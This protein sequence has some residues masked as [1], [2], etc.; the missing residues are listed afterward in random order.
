[1]S[2][3]S[4]LEDLCAAARSHGA[5]TLALTDTNGLYGAVRFIEVA[6]QTGLHPILGAELTHKQHR[7][8]LLSTSMTGYTN[9]CRLLSDRHC[10]DNF[11]F[12]EAVAQH[13]HDLLVL[14]DDIPALIVW[15]KRKQK[16][17]YV[18]LTPGVMMHQAVAFSRRSGIPP[19]ATN[20][21]HFVQPE[22]FSLHTVLQAIALKTTLSQL[23]PTTCCSPNHWLAPAAVLEPQYT[24]IPHALLNA[25]RIAERCHTEWN[26]KETVQQAFRD[27]TDPQTFSTL[28]AKTYEGAQE[29]YGE[30]SR[31][32]EKRIETELSVIRSKGFAVWFLIVQDIVQQAPR[33]CGRG[34]AAASI[35]SYCLGITHVDPIRHN[36]FFERFLNAGRQDPPD[37]DI[38]FPWDERDRILDYIFAKYGTRRTA[39][40]ANHNT[41]GFRAAIREVAKVYGISPTELNRVIP[42]LIRQ[43]EFH[44]PPTTRTLTAW[45]ANICQTMGMHEPW[46]AIISV[47][48]RLEGCLRHLGVHCGGVVIAPDEIQRYVPV[49]VSTKGVPI[50]QWEKDQTEDAGLVKLDILGNRSLAVIRDT[51]DAVE[52]QTGQRLNTASWNPICDTRTQELIRQTKTIGCFY[53]ESPATRLLLRKLWS[54]LPN[55]HLSELDIFEYVVMVSSLVRPAGNPY[56][57][58]FVLRAHGHPHQPVHPIFERV[59]ADTHG[60]MVYQEDVTRV[61]MAMADFSVEDADQLR[62]ILSKKH[63]KRQLQD[64]QTQFS[65]GAAANGA[66]QDATATMWNMIMSFAGYSFCKPHSASYA[67]VS[68]Q[69]AYL[70]AHYPAEFMAA[71]VN[72]QGGFY[73]TFV[74]LSEARRMGLTILPPDINTS[75]W[76]YTGIGHTIRMGFIQIKGLKTDVIDD[77]LDERTKHG[78][79]R[80]LQNFLAR[81]KSEQAQTRILVK[82]GAFDRIAGEVTRAGLLWRLYAHHGWQGNKQRA[83][84]KLGLSAPSTSSTLRLLSHKSV[85]LPIPPDYAPKQKNQHEIELLGFPLNTHPLELFEKAFRGLHDVPACDMHRY[86]GQTITMIGWM[87]TEKSVQTKQREPMEFVTFEDLTGL[88]EATFFPKTYRQFG[89]L[90]TDQGPYILKGIVEEEFQTYSLIVKE[91]RTMTANRSSHFSIP[92]QVTIRKGSSPCEHETS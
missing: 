72:N 1:M 54:A 91:I 42:D 43:T 55:K 88:Y 41:L 29:R 9:L 31:E 26:F 80:S 5:Q 18:E 47:A 77:L 57:R 24:H 56:N 59:L 46:P 78:P 73:S 12:I 32:V 66:S 39:M 34:S 3:V 37:I 70:R 35:V 87:I 36:L 22:D 28:Q 76:K 61:A 16:N 64:Y 63:K 4:S 27:Q 62:K 67:Q 49:Q 44:P 25:R 68:F 14:S 20:R 2:G 13:H 17:L 53:I 50:I 15:K 45:T 30:I 52:D 6:R 10:H 60:L 8:T 65:R 71:V 89:H 74:Y 21:V 90:L 82:A 79:F 7:A 75:H 81:T 85:A 58:D 69:S 84:R 19:V 33:T 11:D 86:A 40:V 48:L 92:N 38:D 83:D 23:P 51:L